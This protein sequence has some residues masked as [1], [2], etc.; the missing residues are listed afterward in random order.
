M[1]FLNKFLGEI[2]RKDPLPSLEECYT[3]V[4]C[5]AV[6]HA[7]LNGGYDNSKSSAMVA[8]NQ[9]TQNWQ[10]RTKADHSKTTTS[11]DKPSYK[12]THCNQTGRT[13]SCCFELVGYPEWW[14]HSCDQRKKNFIKVLTIATVETKTEDKVAETNLALIAAT[15]IGGK[16]LKIYAPISNSTWI[17]DSGATDH[18]TFDSRQVSLLKP[19]SQKLVCTANGNTTPIVGEGSLTFF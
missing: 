19:S 18:M 9:S 12:C 1:A 3:L 10:H 14:D 6:R 17:I 7:T 5:E 11:V 8:R 4:R 16:A 2:L 13:K 15:D